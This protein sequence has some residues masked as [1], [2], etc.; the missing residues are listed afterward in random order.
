[1][2]S[3]NKG[4]QYD[5]PGYSTS[6]QES[7]NATRATQ[8][9]RM[10]MENRVV[11]DLTEVSCEEDEPEILPPRVT[12]TPRKASRRITKVSPRSCDARPPEKVTGENHSGDTEEKSGNS[13]NLSVGSGKH[14]EKDGV[15]SGKGDTIVWSTEYRNKL[16]KQDKIMTSHIT[17][18]NTHPECFKPPTAA[19]LSRNLTLGKYR[20]NTSTIQ[21][22]VKNEIKFWPSGTIR[23]TTTVG[24]VDRVTYSRHATR[25]T[26][27]HSARLRSDEELLGSP[28]TS[29]TARKGQIVT[30]R[31]PLI[32]KSN[33]NSLKFTPE[34]TFVHR[35]ATSLPGVKLVKF[36]N[37]SLEDLNKPIERVRKANRGQQST[38]ASDSSDP[39]PSEYEEATG[40]VR[41]WNIHRDRV[42]SSAQSNPVK[43]QTRTERGL[44]DFGMS[45]MRRDMIKPLRRAH[46]LVR[47]TITVG[48][49][50]T[51]GTASR[52]AAARISPRCAG[53]VARRQITV[54]F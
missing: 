35:L 54:P 26:G 2:S 49:F 28:R 51:D 5:P 52:S 9:G 34:P 41:A 29:L 50:M 19:T 23:G 10:S 53:G 30:N 27:R 45:P 11:R 18:D 4:T 16:R 22:V 47:A 20:P 43:R 37:I 38:P 12:I 3:N 32:S 14:L 44:W 24:D 48:N 15:S 8:D 40:K 33:T 1:M 6:T 17:A 46:P 39:T 36:K 13:E 7:N 25:G 42:G 31:L 21:F